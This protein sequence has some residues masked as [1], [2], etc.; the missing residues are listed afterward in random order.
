[1]GVYRGKGDN[2]TLRSVVNPS[3]GL[4]CSKKGGSNRAII[5]MLQITTSYLLE[6]RRQA[7][8]KFTTSY[9]LK[10]RRQPDLDLTSLSKDKKHEQLQVA[11][12]TGFGTPICVVYLAA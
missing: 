7:I 3:D 2:E 12:T 11:C 1:M 10:Q 4:T 5:R 6:Q 8:L 9:I